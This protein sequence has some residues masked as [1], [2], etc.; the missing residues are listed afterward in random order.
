ALTSA[1]NPLQFA[2]GTGDL[3]YDSGF[4]RP[5]NYCQGLQYHNAVSY[6]PF[7]QK[8]TI[9]KPIVSVKP[10]IGGYTYFFPIGELPY[11]AAP[12]YPNFVTGQ[13]VTYGNRKFIMF[14][15]LRYTET[16][17]IAVEI[18]NV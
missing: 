4:W 5:N 1:G 14:P 17:G 13:E 6:N 9:I 3:F 2:Y 16:H 15:L 7:T 11:Y 10:T 8:A 12:H 18:E